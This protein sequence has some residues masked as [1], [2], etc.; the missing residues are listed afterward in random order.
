MRRIASSIILIFSTLWW[1]GCD[2]QSSVAKPAEVSIAYLW[3]LCEERSTTIKEDIYISGVVVANDMLNEIEKSIVI[4]DHSGGIELKIDDDNI[5]SHIPLFSHVRLRCSGLSIGQEGVKTVVGK[6]PT[7]RYVVDRL[8]I[9]EIDNYLTFI[10]SDNLLNSEYDKLEISDI[11]LGK[12]LRYV[13]LCGLEAIATEAGKSWCE[14][15]TTTNNRYTT[16]IRHLASA[17]DTLRLVVNGN[18]DYASEQIPTRKFTLMGIVDWHDGD[19]AIRI[20][21]HQIAPEM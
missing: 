5:N 10:P 12:M 7:N 21:A 1:C 6:Q 2:S 4:A 18:C 20:T 9:S 17:N 16:T 14:R 13:K 19:V 8:T 15:D 11:D 3:S